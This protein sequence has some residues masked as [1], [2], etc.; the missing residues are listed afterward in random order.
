M[1]HLLMCLK[2]LIQILCNI[3]VFT[4][5]CVSVYMPYA[6]Y[7]YAYITHNEYIE[8]NHKCHFSSKNCKTGWLWWQEPEI[9][10]LGKLR[11]DNI[12]LKAILGCVRYV[13]RLCLKSRAT[14]KREF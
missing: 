4:H 14:R 3:K 9:P 12:N 6:D 5:Y 1:D 13:L 2:L 10:A 8:R 7:I 11:Q